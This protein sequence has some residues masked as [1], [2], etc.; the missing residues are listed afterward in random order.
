MIILFKLKSL[1]IRWKI[2]SKRITIKLPK[3]RYLT[4]KEATAAKPW[5][6]KFRLNQIWLKKM[7]R[8]TRSARTRLPFQGTKPPL[9]WPR[10]PMWIRKASIQQCRWNL[11]MAINIVIWFHLIHKHKDLIISTCLTSHKYK[12][13]NLLPRRR[14]QSLRNNK[15]ENIWRQ[16]YLIRARRTLP[17]SSTHRA[18]YK[19]SSYWEIWITASRP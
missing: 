6:N 8:M 1:T 2:K 5:S 13:L 4:N 11:S 18:H 3:I 14:N 15:I 7:N 16:N 19:R 12:S 17:A 10:E 9:T